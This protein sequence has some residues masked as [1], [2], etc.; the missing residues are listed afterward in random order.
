MA[1]VVWR[2]SGTSVGASSGAAQNLTP[3]PNIFEW[4]LKPALCPSDSE[5]RGVP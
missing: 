2:R 1:R 5:Y 3:Y 4:C